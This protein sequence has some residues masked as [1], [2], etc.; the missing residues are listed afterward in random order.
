MIW[1]TRVTDSAPF[2]LK[3]RQTRATVRFGDGIRHNRRQP[4]WLMTP[5]NLS[6]S[7]AFWARSMTPIDFASLDDLYRFVDSALFRTGLILDSSAEHRPWARTLVVDCRDVQWFVPSRS[8]PDAFLQHLSN[9]AHS[10]VEE[11]GVILLEHGRIVSVIDI[12]AVGGSNSPHI[13]QNLVR[14]AFEPPR[15]RQESRGNRESTRSNTRRRSGK[16][17]L[18]G[19]NPYEILGASATDAMMDIKS[20]YKNLIMQYHPDR[21]SH[22]GPELIELA[23]KKTQELNA[24]YELVRKDKGE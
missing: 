20:K 24:A 10:K 14:R 8:V 2:H 4:S 23:M 3:V 11:K 9:F 1:R 5:G 13:L 22:L 6:R 12:N 7:F 21:V 19:R 17:D 18:G 15:P 16:V